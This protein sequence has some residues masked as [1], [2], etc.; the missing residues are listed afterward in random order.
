[1]GKSWKSTIN[2]GSNGK[3]LIN[4]GLNGTF[5]KKYK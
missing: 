2:G 3:T 1:M 4:V 5:P